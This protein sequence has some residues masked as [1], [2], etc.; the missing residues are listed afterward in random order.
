HLALLAL[1]ARRRSRSTQGAGDG[2]TQTLRQGDQEYDAQFRELEGAAQELAADQERIAQERES[3]QTRVRALEAEIARY[4]AA[5]AAEA[6][7][8]AREMT[9][10]QVERVRPYLGEEATPAL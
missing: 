1:N 7:L 3:W 2:D 8:T 5:P 6:P 4:Q 9:R 10:T